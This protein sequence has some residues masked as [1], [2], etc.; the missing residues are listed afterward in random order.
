MS[1]ATH[2]QGCYLGVGFTRLEN[3]SD[4]SFFE[5]VCLSFWTVFGI[6]VGYENKPGGRGMKISPGGMKISLGVY[7]TMQNADKWRQVRWNNA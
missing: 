6:P 4:L 1:F 7:G 3:R 5:F 2:F